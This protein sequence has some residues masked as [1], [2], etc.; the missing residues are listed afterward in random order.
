MVSH[1]E[2]RVKNQRVET[3]CAQPTLSFLPNSG[4]QPKEW[5]RSQCQGLL[6]LTNIINIT[7]FWCMQRSVPQVIIALELTININHCTL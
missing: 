6:L 1:I 5:H 2:L 7:Y 3:V 4:F